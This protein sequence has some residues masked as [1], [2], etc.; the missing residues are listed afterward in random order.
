M[1]FIAGAISQTDATTM[2]CQLADPN[3][4]PAIYILPMKALGI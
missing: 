2:D 1:S 3:L 4:I